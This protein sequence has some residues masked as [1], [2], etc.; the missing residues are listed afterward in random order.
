M[1]GTAMLGTRQD[2]YRRWGKRALDVV[3]GGAAPLPERYVGRYSRQQAR[4]LEVRPG[5]TGLAQ[6]RGRNTLRW[7]EKFAL[8]VWYVDHHALRLDL[9]LLCATLLVVV[10]GDGVSHPGHATM[11]EFSG[12][13]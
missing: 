12:S 13:R 7:E 6:V 8:D 5:V 3:V 11:E 9:T 4:R 10:R 2:R 1:S